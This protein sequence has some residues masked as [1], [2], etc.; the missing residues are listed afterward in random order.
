MSDHIHNTYTS[1]F[2]IVP[3]YIL[4]LPDI[5]LGY[6]K[7]Y[8]AIFQFWN[9]NKAC[10]LSE[11]SLCTRTTLK[12]SQ[13][14]EALRFFERHG[15]VKRVRKGAKRYLI[16]PQKIIETDCIDIVPM[17]AAPD[18]S[19]IIAQTSGKSDVNVRSAGRTTSAPADYN[20]KKLNKEIK[21]TTTVVDN[22]AQI[23]D[24]CTI[25]NKNGEELIASAVEGSSIEPQQSSSSF[26][27][28]EQT[29]ELLT[30]KLP[31]DKRSDELFLAHCNNHVEK[32][33]NEHSKYQRFSGLKHILTKV[34][35]NREPF[36]SK[37]FEKEVEKEVK[38][39]R[40]PTQEDFQN[41]KKCVNGYD[42]VGAWR[43]KQCG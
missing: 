14:Y 1:A 38:E 40:I 33:V 21:T 11:K 7:V 26:F 36:N 32:Q 30:Y 6:L 35:E 9:H 22:K 10:F 17:S 2:F 15:E 39:S 12:R 23:I 42:W 43:Q 31:T 18:V 19:I 13:I 24:T 16:R 28:K 41:W 5:S 29:K 4:D 3:S 27:S 37:G 25:E 20:N 34:Y 8:E